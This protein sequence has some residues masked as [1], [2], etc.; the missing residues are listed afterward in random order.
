MQGESQP[1]VS[2]LDA[3]R[4]N[5]FGS[6]RSANDD[7]PSSDDEE[8]DED[9]ENEREELEA[10]KCTADEMLAC[11]L[12]FKVRT[13]QSDVEYFKLVAMLR[14]FF[15][16]SESKFPR[17]LY[18]GKKGLGEACSILPTFVVYCP[19]CE[20]ILNRGDKFQTE[21]KCEPCNLDL[22]EDLCDGH[23]QF[24]TLSVRS[25]IE[26]Y[27]QNKAF[28]RLLRKFKL[29][30]A[31]HMTGELH[32][33]IMRQGHFD[34]TFSQDG[35]QLNKKIGRSFMPALLLFNNIPISFQ[36]R[37]PVMA[38]LFGGRKKY[39]PPRSVFLNEFGNEMRKLGQEPIKWTDD[40]GNRCESLVFMPTVLTDHVE[41]EIVMNHVKHSSK[42]ACPLCPIEGKIIKKS[43]FPEVFENHQFR[44]TKGKNTIPGGH[45]FPDCRHEKIYP[46]RDSD[47]RLQIGIEV[48]ENQAV[49]G[50]FK[51]SKEGIKGLP[52][53][54]ALP[55][56]KETESHVSDTL[57]VICHGIFR[58][59]LN[60]MLKGYGKSHHFA[61]TAGR[62]FSVYHDLQRT[63]TRISEVDRNCAL[64]GGDTQ[65]TAYDE[66]Q[67]LLHCVGLV[68]SDSSLID[69]RIYKIL[70]HLSNIVYLSHFG[71]LSDEIINQVEKE[72]TLFSTDWKNVLKE[73]YMTIKWHL[74]DAHW[75][76]FLRN[77]GNASL[78]DGFNME[79]FNL[80]L[81]TCTTARNRE[82]RNVVRN[83]ILEHHSTI[84]EQ[85]KSFGPAAK[86][87]LR[88]LDFTDRFDS[89]F[90]DYI[91]KQAPDQEI[92]PEILR[93]VVPVL[94]E[95]EFLPS[96]TDNET[97]R[98]NLV[99]VSTLVRKGVLFKTGTENHRKSSSVRDCFVQVENEH[100][101][102]IQ[103]II[104]VKLPPQEKIKRFILVVK[105]FEKTTPT[106]DWGGLRLFPINQFPFRDPTEKAPE[107]H[108]FVLR[109]NTFIQKCQTSIANYRDYG[110]RV[111]IM[112]VY[113]NE[114]FRF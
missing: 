41:K 90:Q 27:L 30:H 65:W 12:A 83:F 60:L 36:L 106:H 102:V 23:C 17:S 8:E 97:L 4:R 32:G 55:N 100:F 73:E 20:T 51:F 81:K 104:G 70:V 78:F 19:K 56:F 66:L 89:T 84:P 110:E 77:H 88:I 64:V 93:L 50:D 101:G 96:P 47:E 22:A 103:E 59:V 76:Q 35:A 69:E 79:R 13:R 113:P 57:H 112:S 7:A 53:I 58:D 14:N 16:K 86:K 46:L 3:V 10:P 91:K 28:T 44:K 109:K 111:Q 31:S 72:I 98:N 95:N 68:C 21:A 5:L 80:K 24:A 67:F 26:S 54:F 9:E 37:Y 25:Q 62:D 52:A 11:L 29:H 114:W 33:N 48:A 6:N 43:E 1:D 74:V 34:L 87:N 92:N 105:K 15:P 99:R 82:L 2:A 42:F 39:A 49:T 61:K 45:R 40:L 107:Y 85:L 94:V 71:R 108:V 63:L 38:A 18:L 75:V